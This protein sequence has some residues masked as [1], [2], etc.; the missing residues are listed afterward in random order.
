MRKF[1]ANISL[2]QISAATTSGKLG[3]HLE[4]SFAKVS[5]FWAASQFALQFFVHEV[6]ESC[7]FWK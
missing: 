5:S 1:A 6:K 3:G 2:Q 7:N 4:F